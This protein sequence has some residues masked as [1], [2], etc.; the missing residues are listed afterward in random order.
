MLQRARPRPRPA[1]MTSAQPG[2]GVC[3]RAELL[4]GR[5]RRWYLRRFR[6]EY[7][8]RMRSLRRGEAGDC[9]HEVL[10]PRD[11]K[12]FHP[13]SGYRWAKADDPFAWRDRLP[14]ARWGLAELQ[15]FA[16]PLLAVTALL[17]V[18]S[19]LLAMVP[20]IG[21]A[22]VVYFFRDPAR[23]I[24][25]GAG[26]VVA[27]A[28][29]KVTDVEHIE[30]D[31]YIGGPAVR[32]GIFLSVFNVHLNRAP[33]QSRVIWLRYEPGKFI[34]AL[35]RASAVENESVWIGLEEEEPPH[36]RMIVRQI[37]GA[38]ARR[39]VCDIG[40]GEVLE[41]GQKFGMIKLG[42]RTELYLAVD[43]T[44][45]LQVVAGDRVKAGSSVIACYESH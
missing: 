12:F 25:S 36:R 34:N 15:L 35:R 30:Y 9:P 32:V 14:W 2:G 39:I 7:V 37:A 42:S 13:L 8:R 22:L 45:K 20:A 17:A 26:L 11:L 43:E 16:W 44:L 31:Q 29:G 4:W 27:P 40:P 21:L 18:Y 38:I 33:V 10:D 23:A 24:P 41:R 1:N 28:D 3:Y 19:G 5:M 6:K